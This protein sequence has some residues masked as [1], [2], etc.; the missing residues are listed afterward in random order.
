MQ[1]LKN[2]YPALDWDLGSVLREWLIEPSSTVAAAVEAIADGEEGGIKQDAKVSGDLGKAA[3]SMAVNQATGPIADGKGANQYINLQGNVTLDGLNPSM[4]KNLFGMIQEYGE[5]TGK[6]VTLTSGSRDSK[7]QE[8]LWKKDPKK[9]ARPGYSMHEFGLAFDADRKALNEMDE[10]GLMRKYGF[11]R[12]VGG[13]PWHSEPAGIQTNL[14][15]AKNDPSFATTAIEASLMKGGGGAGTIDGSPLGKRNPTLAI[16]LMNDSAGTSVK[17]TDKD[18]IYDKLKPSSDAVKS[19]Q[20]TTQTTKTST[21]SSSSTMIT[22]DKNGNEITSSSNSSNS[23]QDTKS[24][25]VDFAKKKAEYSSNQGD[26]Y[27]K[28]LPS[29]VESVPKTSTGK[30]SAATGNPQSRDEI[31]AYIVE[32]AKK[33]GIDPNEALLYAAKESGFNP[34]AKATGGSSE[35]LFQFTNGTWK[36]LMGKY[37]NKYGLDPNTPKTDVKASTAMFVEYYKQL[38]KYASAMR[39]SP[40]VTDRYLHYFLGAG[41]ARKLLKA[42]E[43]DPDMLATKILP[44]AAKAN[45][46]Y[47]FEGSRPLTVSEVYK[48]IESS[49]SKTASSF[50]ISLS[51]GGSQASAGPSSKTTD[52]ASAAPGVTPKSAT[53][54][55]PSSS[56]SAPTSPPVSDNVP[57]TATVVSMKE[58]AKNAFKPNDPYAQ[59]ASV[60]QPAQ[61]NIYSSMNDTLN[62]SHDV[63]VELLDVIKGM[64]KTTDLSQIVDLLKSNNASSGNKSANDNPSRIPMDK[65]VTTNAA[66]DLRRKLG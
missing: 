65:A 42:I 17:D 50:G 43:A 55:A 45:P 19:Q 26:K 52:V 39:S 24:N 63:L 49:L 54:A 21:S 12:P 53:P 60:A 28:E 13:E 30:E 3:S 29:E 14:M 25:V 51:T 62:K 10:M 15:L 22:E 64:S 23:S 16:N 35:G 5:K 48:K 34:T 58:K 36:E 9:A 66:L 46:A 11:T 56:S 40:T 20:E 37:A 32:Q 6:K 2:A 41:G 18:L 31:K 59:S 44:D 38:D 57:Q 61:D 1:V 47:F 27:S 4:K 33:Y 7:E 8:A